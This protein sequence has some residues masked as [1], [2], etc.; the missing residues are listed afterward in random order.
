VPTHFLSYLVTGSDNW[1]SGPPATKGLW[2][3]MPIRRLSSPP[4]Y[5]T[6]ACLC[7]I[8]ELS[9]SANARLTAVQWQCL[10]RAWSK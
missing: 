2:E 6:T 3:S 8:G 5:V 4:S 1:N 10:V 7:V 9:Y